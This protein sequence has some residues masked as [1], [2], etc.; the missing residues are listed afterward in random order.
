MVSQDQPHA[1]FVRQNQ[2]QSSAVEVRDRFF[3]GRHRH[4]IATGPAL[5]QAAIRHHMYKLLQGTSTQESMSYSGTAIVLDC[6]A[7]WGNVSL[8]TDSLPRP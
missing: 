4:S 5:Q 1:S 8:L 2:S 6:I 7:G 3:W